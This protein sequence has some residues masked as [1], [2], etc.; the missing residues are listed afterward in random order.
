MNVDTTYTTVDSEGE[1]VF[2]DGIRTYGNGMAEATA[3]FL[4]GIIIGNG[5]YLNEDG[6]QFFEP[7]Y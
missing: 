7:E 1:Y 6:F 4:G 5:Q 3:K 2:K